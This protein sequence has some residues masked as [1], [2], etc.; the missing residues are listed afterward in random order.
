MIG[1]ML[2]NR[3]EIVERIGGGGMALVYRATDTYLGRPVAVKVLR[4][5][6][7]G[8]DDFV[9]R[10]KREAQAAASLS[11]PNV[12]SIYDVGQEDE[13]Y[14]IVMELVD[15]QTLKE[16]IE[17]EAPLPIPVAVRIGIQIL[18]ALEHAHQSKVV[19]RDIKPHNILV[20]RAGRVKVTDFGIARAVST[21]TLTHTGSIIGSAH[22][23]SPEQAK[24]GFTGEK[25]D[26]YSTGIVLYEM[27]T[28][29]VP[30]EG[31]SPISVAVKHLHDDVAPPRQFNEAIPEELEEIILKSLE[32]DPG[33]R[34]Q[35]AGEMLADLSRF[36]KDF[37]E[38]RTRILGAKD[39]PTQ[40][41]PGIRDKHGNQPKGADNNKDQNRGK[42]DRGTRFWVGVSLLLLLVTILG[43]WGL[44]AWLDVPEV[45][46]PDVRGKTMVQAETELRAIGLNPV[47][48]PRQFHPTIPAESVIDQEP[49]PREWAKEGRQV[50]LTISKGARQVAVPLV[51]GLPE[52]EADSKL[53]A[54]GLKS[55]V[56]RREFNLMVP[57]GVVISQNPK[58]GVLVTEGATVDLIVSKGKLLV[59]SVIG[60][61]E[62]GARNTLKEFE[63]TVG[64]ITRINSERPA[65][66]V[67]GQ[68][69]AAGTEYFSGAPVDLTISSGPRPTGGGGEEVKQNT[70]RINVPPGDRS[71]LIEVRVEDARGV[72]TVHTSRQQPGSTLDVPVQWVGRGTVIVLVDGV[73]LR[74]V[75]LDSD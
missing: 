48:G 63:L 21:N 29:K 33:R 19:H 45:E 15:G 9:R 4:S 50:I 39:F 2:G 67:V 59:P 75:P 69:P 65:G 46:V 36:L 6:F 13:L 22:Y 42:R 53:V 27:L 7:V 12:V 73:T 30:F 66:E 43:I 10:F 70:V 32:K 3:Y 60:Q 74:R 20:T 49:P 23:F 38:G 41:I 51:E 37:S 62:E 54:E 58:Q 52:A 34:Y 11:H 18:D 8:D 31:E 17:Q 1:K 24:G 5:Q 55:N 35:S 72:R 28:G 44:F 56:L 71:M 68:S 40:V 14:Y 61:T 64:S 47:A 16:K 26:L 25:S 57:L